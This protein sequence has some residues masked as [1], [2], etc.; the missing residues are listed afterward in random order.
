[1]KALQPLIARIKADMMVSDLQR[2]ASR[3]YVVHAPSGL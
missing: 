3:Q 1:M 2:V